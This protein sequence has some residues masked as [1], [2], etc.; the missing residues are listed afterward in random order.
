MVVFVPDEKKCPAILENWPAEG[1]AV[2]PDGNKHVHLFEIVRWID[3]SPEN[4]WSQGI[5]WMEK[6]EGLRPIR[7]KAGASL[8]WMKSVARFGEKKWNFP[9]E[10]EIPHGNEFVGWP[11]CVKAHLIIFHCCF[12]VNDK[13]HQCSIT[14]LSGILIW[15][16][17]HTAYNDQWINFNDWTFSADCEL[18]VAWKKI[19]LCVRPPGRVFHP[20]LRSGAKSARGQ[21]ICL[22]WPRGGEACRVYLHWCWCCV[23]GGKF[24]CVGCASQ[25]LVVY[26]PENG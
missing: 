18:F 21:D 20:W 5:R 7:P 17:H 26:E 8:S 1:W 3:N 2:A 12:C 10:D 13:W 24:G 11:D 15:R 16:V 14:T 23:N 25:N 6:I 22:L 19:T 9:F 4:A